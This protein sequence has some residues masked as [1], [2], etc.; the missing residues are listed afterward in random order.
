[1]T[2]P[3]EHDPEAPRY[4]FHVARAARER[5]A[6]DEEWFSLSGN[7]LLDDF[8]ASRRL[9]HR[10]CVARE[11]EGHSE[12][13]VRA[14]SL[15]A[16]GLIDE[17][18]HF[19]AG[20]YRQERAPRLWSAALAHLEQRLGR[21]VVDSVLLRFTAEFPP[22][23]VHRGTIDAARYLEGATGGVPHREVA[24]EEL[25]LLGLAHL[26]PAFEPFAELFDE[27]HL[28]GAPHRTVLGEL[29]AYLATQ[30]TFGPDDQSLFVML[31]SPAI[32]HPHSLEGQLD[33]IR[34][35]WGTLLGALL[36]RLLVT[37]DVLH[38][39]EHA[40]FMRFARGG[41]G[42]ARVPVPQFGGLGVEPERFSP[43]REWMPRVVLIAKSAFV[44]LHQLSARG[45]RRVSRLDQIPDEELDQLARSGFTG[46]WLIGVWERSDASRRIKEMMGDPEAAASAYSLADYRISDELG[47]EAALAD[48]RERAWRRGIRLASDMVP[49]HMGLDSRWVVEH[50]DWFVSLSESP[51]PSYRFEGAELS[52]DPRVSIK[53][54]DHYYDRTDAAVVFRRQDRAS[55]ETRFI[56]H[57]NDGTQMPWNDT[58]QLDYLKSEVREAVIQTI[59]HVARNFPIIRFDAAMTLAKRHYQRLWFPEPGTGGAIPSRAERGLT[60][61]AFD[62]VM[63]QEFWREVVD[64]AAVEAPDT[65]LL[66]EAFWLMEGYFVRTLGMHRVYNSAFM[67]ML[68][69]E[70]NANYRSVIKNTLE[71]EPEILKRYV[72]FMNNPDERTAVDQFGKGDKYFGVCTLMATLPGLPM[73]GHGQVEGLSERYG[74]E[75]RRPRWDEQPDRWLVERHEREIFPLLHRRPLFAE[76]SD[77]L[78]YD[79]FTPA[80]HVN[81]DVFAYS[82]RR[83][84]ERSLVVYHNRY[85]TTSG[86]IR[87]SVAYA[88]RTG[89]GDEKATRRRPLGEGLGL[90]TDPAC[91][92]VFR[93]HVSGLEYVRRS[94]DLH[95]RGLFVELEAYRCHVFLDFR[96]VTSDARHPWLDLERELEGRPVP[97]AEAALRDLSLRPVV[98]PMHELVSAATMRAWLEARAHAGGRPQGAKGT[99]AAARNETL[100]DLVARAVRVAHAGRRIA[101]L[102]EWLD[103]APLARELSLAAATPLFAPVRAG[104]APAGNG[105]GQP[106]PAAEEGLGLALVL[107]RFFTRA[108]G[109]DRGR[110]WERLSEWGFERALV[111][112]LRDSGLEAG[113]AAVCASWIE[114][115]LG[116][117]AEADAWIARPAAAASVPPAPGR[118]AAPAPADASPPAPLEAWIADE[119]ARRF[120]GVNEFEGA[121]YLVKER[122]EEWLAG[123]AAMDVLDHAE[124]AAPAR[125][126]RA[127]ARRAANQRLLESAERSGY[128]LERLLARMGS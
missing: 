55:G 19:V 79:L 119:R 114:A 82:N 97:S 11:A 1:M 66:A 25:M 76:V 5:Y 117:P 45:G 103:A 22:L 99:T 115:L 39:E 4:E 37:L 126:A 128:R 20:L 94:A 83:G 8:A 92:C 17:I 29:T 109:L 2:R 32:A 14:G 89:N 90:S 59:L 57:G 46:L 12:P 38:E 104:G 15:H 113:R 122:L 40:W 30:P 84:G 35:R 69:D 43:D 13:P 36:R 75:F 54:E 86:W 33:Y 121:W 52:R 47:G 118:P 123:V 63:P 27:G 16:M 60:K 87:E 91:C 80:G 21:A 96:E 44:W 93:D 41:P 105:A 7:V 48:L 111:Q 64:R 6:F 107:A 24:I 56:Y 68:R 100:D 26:N 112:S 127:S 95:E 98:R 73:F 58:A 23:A 61:E 70:E 101:G 10:M 3:R 74:M 102:E 50:P 85:A 106:A 65:L 49:N 28:A 71:F 116:V 62:A 120:L 108:S 88:A 72:N 81:E 124:L 31:R 110:A 18:L 77:F 125:A 9:A 42:S 53:I 78:L 67:N 51:Y 34:E